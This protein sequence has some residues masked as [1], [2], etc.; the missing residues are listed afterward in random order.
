MSYAR[1]RRYGTCIRI[2][3]TGEILKNGKE[4]AERLHVSPSLVSQC[5]SGQI[6]TCKGYHLEQI[7]VDKDDLPSK[8]YDELHAIIDDGRGWR[9]HPNIKNVYV[10]DDGTILKYCAGR[11]V[12]A[13][14]YDTHDGY[15]RAYINR[16]H[17]HMAHCFVAEAFIPNLDDKPEVN[18]KNGIKSDNVVSNLEWVTESENTRHAYRSGLAKG[19]GTKI[20]VLETGDVYDSERECARAIQGSQQNISACL[21]GKRQTCKG[22]HFEYV[23]AEEEVV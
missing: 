7:N 12:E 10:S 18:H 21:R 23:D 9:E 4:C 11:W 2:I 1:Y 14:Q 13:P 22:Y 15:K 16:E 5:I 3:E 17:Y 20:R 19:R 6:P 8:L